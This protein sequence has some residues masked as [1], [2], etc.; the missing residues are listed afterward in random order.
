[1]CGR[2]VASTP[3]DKLAAYFG[4]TVIAETLAEPS[5]N[6]APTNMVATVTDRAEGRTL[7][8]F[9]WGLVPFWAKDLRIGNRMINARAESVAD[10]NAFR[11]AFRKRR[12]I[13][14][15]DAFY[16]WVALE[17]QKRKQPV[18]VARTDGAPFAFA[19]LWET[20]R[21]PEGPDDAEPV[22]S[23]TII[24]GGPNEKVAK[25]H[26]RMPVMLPP[27]AWDTWLAPDNDDVDSLR[28]LLVPAP[29]ELVEIHA[30]STEVNNPRSR[31]GHLLDPVVHPDLT[32]ERGRVA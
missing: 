26:D 24:T 7:D 9:R 23:C 22:R 21:D 20:W 8:L 4:A 10:K 3:P 13:V 27:G 14:P 1:M 2:F 6:V 32:D 16:E 28:A 25:I 29:P 15:A 11:T 19:G 30:V 5:Y 17:G 18:A 12:C 31:G